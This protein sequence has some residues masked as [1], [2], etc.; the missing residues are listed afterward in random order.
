MA[1]FAVASRQRVV[2]DGADHCLH[3]PVLPAFGRARVGVEGEE[4]LA[5]KGRQRGFQVGVVSD[6]RHERRKPSGSERQAEDGGV[7]YDGALV[8]RQTI[9]PAG[10][11]R[12][13]AGRQRTVGE[14]DAVRGVR[15]QHV[16]PLSRDH[17]IAVD[18]R[19]AVST[20]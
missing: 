13:Q 7:L 18:Q 4:L 11:E 8:R 6:G 14:I 5:D 10:D 12:M 17:G 9:E 15:S 1:R 19:A 2:G 20:A 16:T 3:E